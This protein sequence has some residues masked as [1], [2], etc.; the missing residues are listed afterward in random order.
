MKST[1]ELGLMILMTAFCGLR[2]GGVDLV[3]RGAADQTGAD[4]PRERTPGVGIFFYSIYIIRNGF[5]L[6]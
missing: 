3:R 5:F 2:R 1:N 6:G 4:R